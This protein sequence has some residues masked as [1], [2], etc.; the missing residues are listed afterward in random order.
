MQSVAPGSS[1]T[2]SRW[3][4]LCRVAGVCLMAA[5][6]IYGVS[7]VL[8]LIIGAAP[9]SA[10]LYLD[11]VA[12]H[13][14]ASRVNFGLW[15]VADVLLLPAALAL[16]L[17]LRST[18]KYA[19]LV[20]SGLLALFAVW[21]LSVTELDSLTLVADA[22]RYAAAGSTAQRAAYVAAAKHTLAVLPVATFVS[23]A[24]S[25]VGLLIVSV[26]ML[27][28][29]FSRWTAYAG[30]VASAEGLVGGFYPVFAPLAVL[31]TPSLIA[32]A[33]W[34]V[35]AGVRLNV[36]AMRAAPTGRVRSRTGSA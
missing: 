32:F 15:I 35:L 6:V 29:V 4:G 16:Y 14:L 2:D 25:S 27:R 18:A 22:K 7:A 28:A 30:I 31:L 10:Q 26:V 20:G 21:D 17:V 13:V 19:M 8:S 12:R 9:S 5:G 3:S 34:A 11:S 23:Y 1:D 36:L 24:V 33:V